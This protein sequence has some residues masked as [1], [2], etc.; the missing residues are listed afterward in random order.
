MDLHMKNKVAIVTGGA[1]GIGEKTAEYFVQEGVKVL[2]SDVN[3][4]GIDRAVS[5]LKNMGGVVKGCSC[6]V[7]N[8]K[9]VS[10]MIK[11]ALACFGTFDFLVNSAGIGGAMNPLETARQEEWQRILD[12]N[13]VGTIHCCKAVIPILR[14][15]KNGRIINIASEAGVSGEKGL[16]VYAASKGGVI[17]LTK[18]LAKNLGRDHVTVNTV[19]PAFVHSP[20]TAFLTPELEQKWLKMYVIKRL[21]ETGDVASMIVFLCS[22]RCS[23]I[24]G[25]T[26]SINGGFSMK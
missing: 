18:S 23:W 12:I 19:A 10:L 25:Q 5:S 16:E 1:S 4:E 9:D 20:M 2:I 3:R 11:E 14:E 21:G 15:K 17:A 13:L 6:D 26:I 8:E 24:T 7:T 22:D